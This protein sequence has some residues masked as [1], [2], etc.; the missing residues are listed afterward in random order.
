MS[1]QCRMCPN[2]G[3]IV[4]DDGACGHYGA[5]NNGCGHHGEIVA[6]RDPNGPVATAAVNNRCIRCDEIPPAMGTGR[7]ESWD[8]ELRWS[9]EQR[10]AA[11]D[12][13]LCPNLQRQ[14]WSG[15]WSGTIA[16]QQPPAPL[17]PPAPP[18]QPAL[19]VLPPAPPPPAPPYAEYCDPDPKLMNSICPPA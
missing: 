5:A 2:C 10:E 19:Q 12:Q 18:Q 7:F 16:P 17:Q 8:G 15:I 6:T 9:N 13:L 3:T 14:I 4:L 1:D 11:I